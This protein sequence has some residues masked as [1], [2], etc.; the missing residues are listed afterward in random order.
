MYK[1]LYNHAVKGNSY[2]IIDHLIPHRKVP[3]SA[4]MKCLKYNNRK[5]FEYLLEHRHIRPCS[6]R[7][8]YPGTE[9]SEMYIAC[10][11]TVHNAIKYRNLPLLK[12]LLETQKFHF[13]SLPYIIPSEYLD[14]LLDKTTD[15]VPERYLT[16]LRWV[17]KFYK[18]ENFHLLL[19]QATI[20]LN[21]E[22]LAYLTGMQFDGMTM[23]EVVKQLMMKYTLPVDFILKIIGTMDYDSLVLLQDC[24]LGNKDIVIRSDCKFSTKSLNFI[25]EKWKYNTLCNII[26]CLDIYGLQLLKWLLEH[27]Y[28]KKHMI[29]YTIENCLIDCFRYL[30]PMRLNDKEYKLILVN[31][32]S[33]ALELVIDEF[34]ITEDDIE[35][36]GIRTAKLLYDHGIISCEFINRNLGNKYIGIDKWLSN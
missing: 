34:P 13:Y 23:S 16:E 19:S 36:L 35:D 24:P 10:E 11:K 7:C 12:E 21:Y 32:F 3:R 17:K 28:S 2:R 6:L 20:A 30:L 5:L 22:I 31:D 1:K 14:L 9:W 18:P 29:S 8:L 27:N 33:E 4:F 26:F 15:N 25:N